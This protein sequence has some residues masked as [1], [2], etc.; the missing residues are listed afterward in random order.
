MGDTAA[1]WAEPREPDARPASWCQTK[2]GVATVRDW[3]T[4]R[5]TRLAVAFG[6]VLAS[7][8][9]PWWSRVTVCVRIKQCVQPQRFFSVHHR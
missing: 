4:Q 1:S 3:V 7:R 2:G 6:P 8:S 5:W 9:C